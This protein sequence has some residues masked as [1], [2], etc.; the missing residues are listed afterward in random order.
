MRQTHRD[1]GNKLLLFCLDDIFQYVSLIEHI[2]RELALRHYYLPQIFLELLDLQLVLLYH[3]LFELLQMLH[4]LLDDLV[5]NLVELVE[6]LQIQ[7][8]QLV[9]LKFSLFGLS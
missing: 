6:L 4:V 7:L 2:L 3:M 8:F 5:P 1:L 9:D